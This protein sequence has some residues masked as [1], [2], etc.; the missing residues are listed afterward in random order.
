MP[1]ATDDKGDIKDPVKKDDKPSDLA[2]G[3]KTNDSMTEEEEAGMD[4]K[5]EAKDAEEDKA[6]KDKD[7]KEARDRKSARDRRGGAR[8]ARKSACDKAAAA[9]DKVAKDA[10]EE[11]KGKGMDAAEVTALVKREVAAS[12]PDT[13]ALVL[14]IRKE[15]AAKGALYGRVSPLIGAFDHAEMSHV[16]MA[17]YSLKK[18]G[19]TAA[20]ADPVTALDFYLTG[21]NQA[22]VPLRSA[23]DSATGGESFVDKY[24][25]ATAA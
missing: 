8:D 22:A 5:E 6:D 9:R 16:D 2:G 17:T 11:A 4:A 20:A 3:S 1:K 19:V 18:L 25:Q 13:A 15:E 24:L 23:H 12:T 7:D 14:S 21:R 10:A